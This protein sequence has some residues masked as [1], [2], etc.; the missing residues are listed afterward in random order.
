MGYMDIYGTCLSKASE[1]STH[2]ILLLNI[3]RRFL[4]TVGVH[5]SVLP[6]ALKRVTF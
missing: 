1:K 5:G 6:D 3:K 2:I 4:G